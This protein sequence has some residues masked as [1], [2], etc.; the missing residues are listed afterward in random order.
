MITSAKRLANR[1]NALRSTGPKSA[2]GKLKAS[3]NAM[4]HGLSSNPLRNATNPR[5]DELQQ[6][7]QEEIPDVQQARLIAGHILDYERTESCQ[8]EVA[9]KQHQGLD[10][11]IDTTAIK[12]K[13]L[14]SMA[15]ALWSGQLDRELSKPD[16]AKHKKDELKVYRDALIFLTKVSV[17]QE[18]S[19]LADALTK[20][21]RLRRYY[22][23]ACNQ[24]T[25]TIRA[26]IINP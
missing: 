13:Q 1:R 8:R 23:R 16:L 20:A 19:L 2:Q 18:K 25:K 6:V 12:Q 22:K 10:G 24:L 3:L 21:L 11:F 9:E 14:E 7:I 26:S 15:T 4:Q 5:L 17:Q